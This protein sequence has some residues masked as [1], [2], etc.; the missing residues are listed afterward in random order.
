MIANSRMKR[1]DAVSEIPQD[2]V[3]IEVRSDW[4]GRIAALTAL[5]CPASLARVHGLRNETSIADHLDNAYVDNRFPRLAAIVLR[6][7]IGTIQSARLLD[8]P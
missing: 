3:A 1:P 2:L 5:R 8:R 6:R 4:I 7:T